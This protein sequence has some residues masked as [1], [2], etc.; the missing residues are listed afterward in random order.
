MATIPDPRTVTL[1]SSGNGS[2]TFR[3]QRPNMIKRIEKITVESGATG[4]GN[5]SIFFRGQLVSSKAIA[6]LM[7]AAGIMELHCGEEVEVSFTDGPIS[8]TMK[9]VAHYEEIPL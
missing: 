4:S 7:T 9:V 6:L 2:V 3:G 8:A 5:V 1:S